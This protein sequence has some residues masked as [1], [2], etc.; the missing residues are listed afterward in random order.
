MSI[1]IRIYIN[2]EIDIDQL[3]IFADFN[4]FLFFKDFN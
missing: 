2:L 1:E 4:K 3:S